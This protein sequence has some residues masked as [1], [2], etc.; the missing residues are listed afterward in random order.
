MM[1]VWSATND[2]DTWAPLGLDGNVTGADFAQLADIGDY[3][4]G[5]IVTNATA[6]IIRSQGLSYATATGNATSP[7]N[8]AHIGLG[9][10]GEGSQITALL[11]QYDQAGLYVGN[12]DIYQVSNGIAVVGTKIK[13]ALFD[14]LDENSFRLFGNAA[15]AVMMTSETVLF[16]LAVGNVIYIYN[17]SNA[18]WQ[19][20][21]LAVLAAD[22]YSLALGV[23]ASSN[24]T[25]SSNLFNQC[26]PIVAVELS[27]Q[28]YQFYELSEGVPN[29]LSLS[30]PPTVSFPVE[31]LSFGRDITI[32]AMYRAISAAVSGDISIVYSLNG[33]LFTTETLT[34]AKYNSVS[35]PP[36]EGQVFSSSSTTAG[37]TTVHSP[38]LQISITPLLSTGTA[39]VRL[40]K[41]AIFG[42]FDPKQR[43]V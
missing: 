30:E 10:E 29:I 43:P 7:F 22:L 19:T 31:E 8:F 2:L 5:L 42:S 21:T 16:L 13:K 27:P 11:T 38:Q 40:T 33:A 26:S 9:D 17:P 25:A 6:F 4:T 39:L 3:L 37:A 32:D 18:T 35:V 28:V 20:I 36:I 15:C 41:Q 23:F 14:A 12:S 34:S 24:T 1:F